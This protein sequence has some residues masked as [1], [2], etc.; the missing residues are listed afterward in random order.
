MLDDSGCAIRRYSGTNPDT[1]FSIPTRSM[2]C[3]CSGALACPD[4]SIVICGV[5]LAPAPTPAAGGQADP[6]MFGS[7]GDRFDFKGLNNTVYN[8][9]SAHH[10][11]A[12]VLFMHDTFHMG[13]T[14]PRCSTKTVH[15]SFMKEVFLNLTTD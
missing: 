14:C 7:H 10:F 1:S 9:F 12:N 11:A 2:I 6:H 8:V 5:T 15:G 13:G 3:A 4:A